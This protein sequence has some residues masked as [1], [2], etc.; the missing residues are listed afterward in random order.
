LSVIK[1]HDTDVLLVDHIA[2]EVVLS[3]CLDFAALGLLLA[4]LDFSDV[5][6]ILAYFLDCQVKPSVIISRVYALMAQQSIRI[7]CQECKQQDSTELKRQILKRFHPASDQEPPEIYAPGGGCPACHMAGY[8]HQVVLFEIL[9]LEPWLKNMLLEGASLAN[10]QQMAEEREF[11]SLE[12][13]SLGLLFSGQTSLEEV[14]SIL[15]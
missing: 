11:Q 6:Q 10:I 8:V 4:S 12:K 1:A 3:Q 15:T 14:F 13:K 5:F 2:S 7:L 9:P